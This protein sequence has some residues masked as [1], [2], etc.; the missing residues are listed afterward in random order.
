MITIIFVLI[1]LNLYFILT[2]KPDLFS[3]KN[4]KYSQVYFPSIG[5][6]FM[7]ILNEFYH[8]IIINIFIK[9]LPTEKN[10]YCCGVTFFIIFATKMIRIIPST[11]IIIFNFLLKCEI[12]LKE[13]K[14][15]NNYCCF[16]YCNLSLFGFQLFILIFCF[17]LCLCNLSSL[18]FNSRN[19]LLYLK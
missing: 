13:E 1:I 18:R 12:L 19:R 11:I 4:T 16:N 14:N 3:I 17:I 15:P 9:L 6:F 5:I 10:E 8:I 7:I 2:I